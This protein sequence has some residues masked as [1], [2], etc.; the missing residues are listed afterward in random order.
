MLVSTLLVRLP[1]LLAY[2]IDLPGVLD[3]QPAARYL[4]SAL[5]ILFCSVQISLTLHNESLRAALRAHRQFIER[6]LMRVAWFLL[7]CAVHFFAL[8]VCDAMVRGA[9]ADRAMGV[10]L[11]KGFYVCAR[12]FLTGWL[13][14]SWACLFRQCET[15]RVNQETWIKY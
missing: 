10:I 11:W 1:L 4:M 14:A 2:F 3:Y 9:V 5:I 12:G 15:G 6:N 8:T 7:I 13:L